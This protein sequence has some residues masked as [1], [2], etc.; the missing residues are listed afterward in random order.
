[1]YYDDIRVQLERDLG[2]PPH[3]ARLWECLE[4]LG[5]IEDVELGTEDYSDLL[6]VAKIIGRS[7]HKALA[8]SQTD[9]QRVGGVGGQ[10]DRSG[11]E[12]ARGILYED[13]QANPLVIERAEASSAY[14]AHCAAAT[15]AV[16]AF[17]RDILAGR[18]LTPEQAHTFLSSPAV[19]A[20][21]RRFFE[22]HGIPF[23]DHRS[24]VR[25]AGAQPDWQQ[26]LYVDPPGV[27]IITPPLHGYEPLHVPES[28][29]WYTARVGSL[30]D[31]LR[32]LDKWLVE[33]YHCWEGAGLW[34][35]LTGV[36]FFVPPLRLEYH[37]T[38]V[39]HP[40]TCGYYSH[41]YARIT[42]DID[43]WVPASEVSRV[44][45]AVQRHALRG[46]EPRSARGDARPLA[47]LRLALA[48]TDEAGRRR[49]WSELMRLWNDAHPDR[50]YTRSELMS[51]DFGRA[52]KLIVMPPYATLGPLETIGEK[53]AE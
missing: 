1:M 8:D 2:E 29:E 53:N 14:L 22:E 45:S 47:V 38:R 41:M 24:D 51:R 20:L 30:L 23:V 4:E 43:P 46:K 3:F 16:R 31:D 12:Q 9:T 7:M 18:R 48:H 15:K 34:F 17:R 25:E 37:R 21:P 35:V 11:D 32:R 5:R 6:S 42:L 39:R 44:Y 49:Q 26:Q 33:R 52:L 10:I 13:G 40:L 28:Q 19:V 27:T 50:P 36:P